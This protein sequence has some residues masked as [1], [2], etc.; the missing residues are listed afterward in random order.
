MSP[1]AMTPTRGL[2]FPL[3]A[4]TCLMFLLT[5][6]ETA[7]KY[8]FTYRLWDSE[9]LRKWSEPAPNPNLALF[10]TPD[11]SD[12]LVRYDAFSEKHSAIECRAYY[13]H[14]NT[15]RVAAGQRPVFVT[16]VQAESLRRIPVLNF[17]AA[18]NASGRPTDYAILAQEGRAFKLYGPVG[19]GDRFELPV[20]PESAGTGVRLLE[21]PLAVIGDVVMVGVVSAVAATIMWAQSGAPT[22]W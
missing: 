13:L 16:P 7:R 12:V 10:A 1:N 9:D 8:S 11:G 6:C 21:T 5:G 2:A 4:L 19:R 15:A 20:Y 3:M 18:T 22:G 14:S 17:E